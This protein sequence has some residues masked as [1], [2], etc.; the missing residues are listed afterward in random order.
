LRSALGPLRNPSGIVVVA[1]VQDFASTPTGLQTGDI[2]HSL[3]R[4]SIDSV[5]S[6]R[7]AMQN[8]KSHDPVVLQIERSGGLQ[9]LAFEM[10]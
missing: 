10:E 7:A 4:V 8:I 3:N 9:W 6:I 2:I 1:R 5:S